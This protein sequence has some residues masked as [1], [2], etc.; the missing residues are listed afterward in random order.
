MMRLAGH[1]AQMREGKEGI[2]DTDGKAR[3]KEVK[4]DVGG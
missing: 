1:V 3:R 4:I 2:Q